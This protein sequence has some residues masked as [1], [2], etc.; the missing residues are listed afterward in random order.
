MTSLAAT[1]FLGPAFG[2][3]DFFAGAFSFGWVRLRAD[4]AALFYA[5]DF[6]AL[7]E[8]PA[9]EVA[10]FFAISPPTASPKTAH[11]RADRSANRTQVNGFSPRPDNNSLRMDLPRQEPLLS[12]QPG[13]GR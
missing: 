7:R 5:E 8:A 9:L 10:A 11:A 1:A 3:A 6:E 4:L 12:G 2:G 13:H